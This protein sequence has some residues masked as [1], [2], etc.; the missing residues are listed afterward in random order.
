MKFDGGVTSETLIPYFM[1]IFSKRMN[2]I[3][4]IGFYVSFYKFYLTSV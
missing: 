3:R 2:L 1:S 4:I